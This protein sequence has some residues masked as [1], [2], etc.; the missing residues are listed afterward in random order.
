[1]R[2]ALAGD[3]MLGRGVAEALASRPP[4]S[5]FSREV[6]AVMREADLAVLNL[7][8]CISERG[9]PWPDPRKP[10][11][12]RAPPVA[13]ETLT[14]LGVD[15]VTLANNHALDFG[16]EALVDTFAHLSAAGIAWVGAGLD[17]A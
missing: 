1:M 12:F 5:L 14:H 8:C 10:F 15:C 9:T 2:L 17:V 4:E 13:V 3:T 11:F 6:V 16:E 7:E